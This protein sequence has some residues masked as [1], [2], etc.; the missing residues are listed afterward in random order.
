MFPKRFN[1]AS[2]STKLITPRLITFDAYNTLYCTTLP[3]IEQYMSVAE[4][5]GIKTDR[6]K[7]VNKFTVVFKDLTLKYPNYGKYHNMSAI[8]WWSL[9]LT[10]LFT[11]HPISDAMINDILKRFQG[12]EAYAVY[13][14]VLNFL[15][16]CQL[17]YPNV[18][19][20]II[21]N[22]DPIVYI[23]LENLGI[24]DFFKDHLYLSYELDISK[25]DTRIFHHVINDVIGRH[26]DILVGLT[27][28][29]ELA[30]YCW[31]I[32]DEMKKD[33]IAANNAGW[34]AIL[35]DRL[36]RNGFFYET[37]DYKHNGD[38]GN[39]IDNQSHNY[40]LRRKDM[41]EYSLQIDKIDQ[42]AMKIWNLSKDRTDF[43][44]LTEKTFVVPNINTI[45]KM[46]E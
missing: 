9:L 33:M 39:N 37:S 27:Q 21:S 8:E 24:L 15:K 28:K 10:Q 46:F 26:P 14:D 41:N 3:V 43:I 32:G 23:L 30:K 6:M 13:P 1:S 44:Q 11:P 17:Q 42:H 40:L 4:I 16:Y 5:Y 36:N 18:K 19:L 22:T 34:N 31:H 29:N 38:L 2:W 45:Q 35:V 20:G 12:Q 25:P 7:L